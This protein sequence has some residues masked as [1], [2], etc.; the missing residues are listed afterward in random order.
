M[1]MWLLVIVNSLCM[2][3][4]EKERE[5]GG[6]GGAGADPGF[7]EGGGQGRIQDFKGGGANKGEGQHYEA[8]QYI[9]RSQML[10]RKTK[11]SWSTGQGKF[12]CSE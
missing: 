9:Q 4:S 7:Q 8:M 5:W 1:K 2:A 3:S 12:G 6:G 10:D 11:S